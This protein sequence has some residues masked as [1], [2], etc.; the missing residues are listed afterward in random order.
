MSTLQEAFNFSAKQVETI[1]RRKQICTDCG[2][3][4]GVHRLSV[5]CHVCGCGALSL[6][7]GAC[8]AGKWHQSGEKLLLYNYH[9]PGDI[10]VMTAAVRDLQQAHPGKYQIG[11]STHIPALWENN[12]YIVEHEHTTKTNDVGFRSPVPED[13]T[14]KTI[15]CN[16]DLINQ[17]NQLPYHYLHA[18]P[19][20]LSK[21]LGVEIP[22]TKFHGDIHLSNNEK[23]WMS[24]VKEETGWDGPFWIMMAGGKTDFTCKWWGPRMYQAVVDHF[25]DRIKFVQCGERHHWHVPLK[26]VI[27]FIGK[28]DCRKFVRLMYHADGV[29]CPVT[30]AMHLAAAVPTKDESLRPCVVIAGG[31]EPVHWEQYPGH[32]FLHTIGMLDCCLTGGCWKSR[33]QKTGDNS[34]KEKGDKL[35]T[36]TYMAEANL[37]I[38]KCMKMISPEM[39]INAIEG[40][41]E[42]KK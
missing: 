10:T 35:C 26:N 4:N 34:D 38:P 15:H 22:V 2:K 14:I 23:V 13:T 12:P 27:N 33:C 28:T 30:F 17:S 31:R 25:K 37:R 29:V 19:Q 8:K 40:Y 11:V 9:S 21:A 20:T 1:E 5:S 3:H 41:L 18:M 16:Y 36:H 7:H 24:Q 32:Q 42:R 6:L 39:V